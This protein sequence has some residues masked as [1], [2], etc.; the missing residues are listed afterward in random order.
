M[1]SGT[2]QAGTTHNVVFVA[3]E[4]DS[5]YAFDADSNGG[6]NAS[7]LWKITLLDT[8]HGAGSGATTVPNG[9][10]GTDDITPEIGI[11]ATP[12][13][14]TASNTIYVVGK[15]KENG[16]YFQRLHALDITTGAEKSGS[17]V[18][19]AAQVNGNGNGSSGGVLRFD[20][21]LENNRPGLLLLNGIVYIAFAAHG[22]QGPYHGWILAYN[23]ANV[24]QQTSVFCA[25]AN[26]AASGIWMSG[27]GLAADAINSGRLFVATGNGAFNATPSYNNSM[28][29]GD[30]LIRLETSGGGMRVS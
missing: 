10:V 29:Y 20:A 12:V 1:G 5:V 2:V 22:D 27:A 4:H 9:D 14:D 13:I 16:N 3:T 17:P 19:L 6:S 15:T 23:A 11:T 26:G 30:D 28:S 21:K 8:A 18:T 25:T 24:Q 7:P